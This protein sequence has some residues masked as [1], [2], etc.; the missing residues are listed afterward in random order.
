MAL[1]SNQET[2]LEEFMQRSFGAQKLFVPHNFI[3]GTGGGVGSREPAD[4]A[5]IDKDFI[6]LFYMKGG[7]S[8]NLAK[9]INGNL[10]QARG[11]HRL[12]EKRYDKYVLRGKNKFDDEAVVPYDNTQP[13]VNI[14]VVSM[15]CGVLLEPPITYKRP[16]AVLVIP[17]GLIKIVSGFGGT[18]VDLLKFSEIFIEMK[19]G[20]NITDQEAFSLLKS[21]TQKYIANAFNQADPSGMLLDG[22]LDHDYKF[23]LQHLSSMKL[24]RSKDSKGANM[25]PESREKI[26]DLFGDLLLVEYALLAATAEHI[27]NLSEPPDFNNWVVARFKVVNYS[28]VI[29]TINMGASNLDESVE[30][31]LNA[32]HDHDGVVRSTVIMYGTISGNNDYKVPIIFAIPEFLPKKHATVLVEHLIAMNDDFQ[33]KLRRY[34]V[35]DQYKMTLTI[36]K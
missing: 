13:L 8:E 12:W 25:S 3:M 36:L 30:T 26:S 21:L 23:I 33:Y 14:L 32:G 4:L 19:V 24:A 5:W 18:I 1:S 28:F 34:N 16:N 2:V 9:Q 31:A 15:E 11:F 20:P 10:K 35:Q 29:N 27:I 7:K 22:N 6:V 17:E